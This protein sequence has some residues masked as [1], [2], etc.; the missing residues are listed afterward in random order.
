[1]TMKTKI[2]CLSHVCSVG[3]NVSLSEQLTTT[4]SNCSDLVDSESCPC[5]QLQAI[6]EV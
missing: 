4:S 2:I 3:I 1:M 6:Y 5:L